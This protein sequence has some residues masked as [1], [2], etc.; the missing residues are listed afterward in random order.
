M[1]DSPIREP[2]SDWQTIK[3]PGFGSL[4][5][6]TS[7]NWMPVQQQEASFPPTLGFRET[8]TGQDRL[9]VTVSP[10]DAGNVP[11]ADQ[12]VAF[13]QQAF[14]QLRGQVREEK[15]ELCQIS[16]NTG[17]G[18][19]FTVTDLAP[20]AGE[21]LYMTS[22]FVPAG[23]VLL[24]FTVLTNPREQLLLARALATIRST[25]HHPEDD[26]VA[27]SAP[28]SETPPQVLAKF[29]DMD[30]NSEASLFVQIHPELLGDPVQKHLR[31][32][33]DDTPKGIDHNRYLGAALTL[34]AARGL[35]VASVFAPMQLIVP[36]NLVCF[37]ADTV[38]KRTG[39]PPSDLDTF[40]LVLQTM[41]DAIDPFSRVVIH[42]LSAAELMPI[43][44][45]P[46][47][48]GA[49]EK[50]LGHLLAAQAD[51]T[52]EQDVFLRATIASQLSSF[53]I[54]R[55]QDERAANLEAAVDSAESALRDLDGS[56]F[57]EDWIVAKKRLGLA[58]AKRVHGYHAD[59]VE[60]AIE[61]FQRALSFCPPDSPQMWG[62]RNNLGLAF[63]EREVGDKSDNVR[64]AIEHFGTALP[65]AKERNKPGIQTN[66][67][68]AWRELASSDVEAME[69]AIAFYKDAVLSY[70]HIQDLWNWAG[71]QHNLG[72]AYLERELGKRTDNLVD[73]MR[74][75]TDALTVRTLDHPRE[76]RST[77]ILVG[78][79]HLVSYRWSEAS[80]AYAAAIKADDIID[81]TT[82]TLDAMQSES[83]NMHSAYVDAAYCLLRLGRW[84]EAFLI[85]EKGSAR[86]LG[87][88]F[89]AAFADPLNPDG[90]PTGENQLTPAQLL[91]ASL[92]ALDALRT[93]A[94]QGSPDPANLKS[95]DA[96]RAELPELVVKVREARAAIA[97]VDP[98]LRLKEY[99]AAIR[100]DGAIVVP[101]ITKVGSAAFVIPGGATHIGAD[102]IVWIDNFTDK[103]L[104][105]ILNGE[106]G[107]S[108][109]PGWLEA[110]AQSNKAKRN[111][112]RVI[113]ITGGVLWDEFFA[114]I[115]AR[116]TKLG[117][118]AG[119]PLTLLPAA[120]LS[121]LPLHASWRKENDVT[122]YLAEDYTITYC[123]SAMVLTNSREKLLRL[124]RDHSGA[125]KSLLVV[126]NPTGDLAFATLEGEAIAVLGETSQTQLL[127]GSKASWS[128]VGRQ[129][130]GRDYI[131]FACHGRYDL[132]YPIRS[133]LALAP[134]PEQPGVSGFLRL[135]ELMVTWDNATRLVTLSAC[136]TGVT[137]IAYAPSEFTGL[138][139]GWLRTGAIAVI[140]S[141]W[142]VDD[143][144]TMLLMERLYQSLFLSHN[145]PAGTVEP[146]PATALRTAQLW[147][148]ELSC[149][150]VDKRL[151]ALQ[152][153]PGLAPEIRDMIDFRREEFRSE[154]DSSKPF[155]QPYWW[156]GF[157]CSGV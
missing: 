27:S 108:Q 32:A 88:G 145:D 44:E 110:Y 116:L 19:F 128:E 154:P 157:L 34:R 122:R 104:A 95:Q 143:L 26:A 67:G 14:D 135:R 99:L 68:N 1:Q 121:I 118:L 51:C 97:A 35:G 56:G 105:R 10:L 85:L 46:D 156:A 139:S 25:V 112:N 146:S 29:L 90:E 74:C 53:F 63:L 33:A 41:A 64:T 49:A 81:A 15:P 43:I 93:Y 59:N 24:S 102:D 11:S 75:L 58:S 153:Q 94:A 144:C 66:L 138:S 79:L 109:S 89:E 83:Q 84:E 22:G 40:E 133:F 149:A 125:K 39:T 151:A 37:T 131:H 55:V 54:N 152:Q 21:F 77:Q 86:T 30:L 119:A 17:H 114:S 117:L 8:P 106:P 140:S 72:S 57:I 137:D 78:G 38:T 31:Q 69:K 9:I 2:L 107:V 123:P 80:A 100:T 16:T 142:L 141:L 7:P 91:E 20:K 61:C 5:I 101:I 62:L 82:D 18:Y 134:P 71:V 50:A 96:I 87:R 115:H 13:L 36:I 47:G 147:L 136:E 129:F 130:K 92:D 12:L 148:K 23:G 73:A 45:K 127:C 76:H 150:E 65:L 60:Y 42:M 113:S 28:T 6:P 70:Q 103:V 98:A 155:S 126:A 132:R 52:R 124:Q 111:W 48:P 4:Q 120:G 3:L